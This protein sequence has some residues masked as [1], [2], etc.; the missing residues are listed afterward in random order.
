M[1]IM[2]QFICAAFLLL[3]ICF[4]SF[5]QTTDEYLITSNSVGKVQL[6]MTLAEV[7]KAIYPLT[8]RKVYRKEIDFQLVEIT[9]DEEILMVLGSTDNRFKENSK[10]YEIDVR[11][12]K[13]RTTEGVRIGTTASELENLLK[14]KKLKVEF[15][16]GDSGED[17]FELKYP[18]GH[19]K[20]FY[21]NSTDRFG[22]RLTDKI[23]SITVQ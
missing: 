23:V 15:Y 10:V 6:G 19:R 17:Y 11:S 22:Y 13:F 4:T 12:S 20:F 3:G 2:R 7:R 18:P 5:S 21:I 8:I 14:S 9:K 1:D 16:S